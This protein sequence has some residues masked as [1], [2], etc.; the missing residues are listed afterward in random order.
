MVILTIIALAILIPG[1]SRILGGIFSG[2]LGLLGL[3]FLIT[4]DSPPK[5]NRRW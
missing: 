5:A 2:V 1:F 4:R 3:T